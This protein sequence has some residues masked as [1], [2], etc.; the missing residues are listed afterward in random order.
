MLEMK[1]CA[2]AVLRNFELHPLTRERDVRFK[3]DLVLRSAD[4]ILLEF[5]ERN[6]K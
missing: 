3:S 6:T 1:S 5:V 4:P 2:A